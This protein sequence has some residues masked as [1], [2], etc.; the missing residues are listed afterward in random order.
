MTLLIKIGTLFS[1]QKN[2]YSAQVEALNLTKKD[3]DTVRHFALKVEPLVEKGLCNENPSTINLKCN[4]RTSQ[5]SQRL[6]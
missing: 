5:V 4:K 1:Y 6:C 3:N 2:A